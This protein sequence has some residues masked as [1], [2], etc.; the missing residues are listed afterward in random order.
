MNFVE[1]LSRAL[2]SHDQL[3]ICVD[4]ADT[5]R[6]RDVRS[7][8]RHRN[9]G[10]EVVTY[11][12]PCSS[13]SESSPDILTAAGQLRSKFFESLSPD[14]LLITSVFEFGTCYSTALDWDL[15]GG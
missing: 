15:L 6:L 5:E 13:F 14:I 7:E 11:G 2:T 9:I 1:A 12:Y 8:L 10:G 3:I 4:T